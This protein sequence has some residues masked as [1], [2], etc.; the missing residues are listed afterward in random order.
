MPLM[1]EASDWSYTG[2]P[3]D[4]DKDQFRFWLQD[5]DPMVRLLSDTEV[6]WLIDTWQPRYDSLVYAAAVGAE[7]IATKFAGV[8]TVSADG[9]SVDVGGLSERYALVAARLRQTHKDLQVGGEVDIMNLL[10]D[11]QPD[12]GI[13]PLSFGVGMHDNREAG[14]QDYGTGRYYSRDGLYQDTV[15]PG[16]V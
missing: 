12:Y 9:V 10:W 15:R 14:R 3:D 2:D 11:D 7:T 8:L 4:S 1:A 16:N 13:K 6:Q 5:T